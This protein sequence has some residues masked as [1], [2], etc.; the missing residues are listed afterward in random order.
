MNDEFSG[1]GKKSCPGWGLTGV[2][3]GIRDNA[4]YTGG[5]T[6]KTQSLKTG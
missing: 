3:Y 2:S 6:G 1:F 4:S 5:N